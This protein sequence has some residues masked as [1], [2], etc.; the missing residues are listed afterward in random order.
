MTKPIIQAEISKDGLHRL[1][2]VEVTKRKLYIF[3]RWDRD[4]QY[5]LMHGNPTSGN[6][7]L[8]RKIADRLPLDKVRVIMQS[9]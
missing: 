1:N 5:F 8:Y 9:V 2:F 7:F 4:F 3:L 6:V